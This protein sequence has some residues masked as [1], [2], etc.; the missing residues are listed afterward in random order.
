MKYS[1]YFIP[2]ENK[3]LVTKELQLPNYFSGRLYISGQKYKLSR[4]FDPDNI[5]PD[6]WELYNLTRDPYELNNSLESESLFKT[7]RFRLEELRKKH[8]DRYLP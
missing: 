6:E 3:S 5:A 1:P 2:T 4:Y 8:V 7:L